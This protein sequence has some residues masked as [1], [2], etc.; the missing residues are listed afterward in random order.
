MINTGC[1]ELDTFL[2]GGF[3]G[4]VIYLIYGPAAS[5][6]TTICLQTSLNNSKDGKI[7]YIDTEGGFSVDRVKQMSEE[8]EAHLK[9]IVVLRIKNF[10]DQIKYFKNLNEVMKIGKFN[11]LIIDSL[12]IHYRKALQEENYKEVND[13]LINILRSLK[14]IAEDCNI[15]VIIT[16]QIYSNMQGENVLVGGNMLKKFGKMIIELK[17]KPRIAKIIKPEE[18]VFHFKIE[19]NGIKKL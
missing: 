10:E 16:N 1:E 4:G 19:D 17:T 7:L 11:L 6:K 12:S 15:P 8:Y 3:D 13:E 14:H 18:S 5:G 2:G 9:N